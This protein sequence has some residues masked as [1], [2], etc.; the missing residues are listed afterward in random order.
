MVVA[1]VYGLIPSYSTDRF[2]FL[3]FAITLSMTACLASVL[4]DL[5]GAAARSRAGYAWKGLGGVAAIVSGLAYEVTL[6]LLVLTPLLMI[7]RSWQVFGR[8]DRRRVQYLVT[9]I[10]VHLIVLS[11]I[12]AFK[13]QTTVRLGA[14]PGGLPAQVISIARDAVRPVDPGYGLNVFSAARVHFGIYGVWLPRTTMTAGGLAPRWLLWSSAGL[15]AAALLFLYVVVRSSP[16]PSRQTWTLTIVAGL[17]V[18]A[19]G[20]AIFLTNYN[21][22]FT[23]AGIANRSAIAAALGAAMCLTAA[24]GLFASIFGTHARGVLFAAL[25]ATMGGSGFL[26]VNVIA[27]FWHEAYEREQHVLAAIQRRFPTLPPHSTLL[28]DGVCPYAGPAVVFESNWDLK[29]ALHTYYRDPTLKADVVTPRLSV[30]DAGIV[31]II[32]GQPTTYQYDPGLFVYH[33][34]TGEVRPLPDV[35]SARAYFAP[36]PS[37]AAC[38]EAVEGVGVRLF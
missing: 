5:R 6:G 33:A 34:G 10:A 14:T 38:P 19:A 26:I 15:A 36:V 8:P 37:S 21:V 35:A 28:L 16:W 32:Y 2:W 13:L 1:F 12:A 24:A 29:G 18:F 27:R 4:A 7:I 23:A 30:T 20:Y 11:A 17:I 25:I 9:L 22:Q 31:T 3:A